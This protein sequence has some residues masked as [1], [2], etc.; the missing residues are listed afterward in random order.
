MA[1]T[2]IIRLSKPFQELIINYLHERRMSLASLIEKA[3]ERICEE[4]GEY[5]NQGEVKV[6]GKEFWKRGGESLR[7]GTKI[8]EKKLVPLK[9]ISELTGRS[10]SD[11]VKEGIWKIIKEEGGEKDASR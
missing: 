7:L 2:L 8:K 6:E 4:Y 5:L 3:M 1:R 9:K 10:I 11:L